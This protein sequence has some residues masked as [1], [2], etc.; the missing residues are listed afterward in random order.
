MSGIP[1][2]LLAALGIEKHSIRDSHSLAGGVSAETW[3][4]KTDSRILVVKRALEQLKV[5]AD[6]HA[7]P[8]RINSEVAWLRFVDSFMPGAVPK[9]L[10]HA[11]QLYCFSMGYL[12][13]PLW[14]TELL[15][16][17]VDLAFTATVA[18]QLATIH[19]TSTQQPKVAEQF[20]NDAS[21]MDLRVEPYFLTT[22]RKNPEI[23]KII[24]TLG[25]SLLENKTALMQGDISPKNIL[26]GPNGAVFLDAETACFGDPAFDMAFCLTHLMLKALLHAESNAGDADRF[27][28]AARL[29]LDEYLSGVDWEPPANITPRISK[30]LLVIMLARVDGKSPVNYLDNHQQLQVRSFCS[31]A[32]LNQADDLD[33]ITRDW[34]H[35][36]RQ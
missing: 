32:L 29:M 20:H 33:V 27:T 12:D 31:Q 5:A 9:I 34:F 10:A 25:H 11:P 15:E 8:A 21:F 26:K 7:D 3:C 35:H 23:A 28:A 6:W 22:A 16:G 1:D 2:E 18:R 36:I 17:T 30:L 4:I 14:K 19:G 24:T 13:Y